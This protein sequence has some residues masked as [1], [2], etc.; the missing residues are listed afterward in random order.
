[1]STSAAEEGVLNYLIE[2]RGLD[3]AAASNLLHR[4][5]ALHWF[6]GAEPGL[7]A[8]IVAY[9]NTCGRDEGSG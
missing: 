1:M 7:K 6:A 5:L 2:A 8:L 3:R 9:K 4:G